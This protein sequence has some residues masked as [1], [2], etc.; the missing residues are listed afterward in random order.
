MSTDPSHLNGTNSNDFTGDSA[1]PSS[2]GCPAASEVSRKRRPAPP[3]SAVR[4]IKKATQAKHANLKKRVLQK[5]KERKIAKKATSLK[6]AHGSGSV[7]ALKSRAKARIAAKK[8]THK[9]SKVNPKAHLK[10]RALAV[11]SKRK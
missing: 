1:S 2:A 8:M 7:G 4:A 6:G 11:A 3:K 10:N 5:F 9:V